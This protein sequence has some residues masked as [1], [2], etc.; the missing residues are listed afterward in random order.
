[1]CNQDSTTEIIFGY[2]FTQD[3]FLVS[4]DYDKAL[5]SDTEDYISLGAEYL[6]L[7]KTIA[8]RSGYSQELLTGNNKHY[9]FGLGYT[10]RDWY[11]KLITIDTSYEINTSWEKHNNLRFSLKLD[12]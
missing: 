9:G 7:D 1:M 6:L 4:L 2:S 8:L 3:F 12:M 10:L 5:H 11:N